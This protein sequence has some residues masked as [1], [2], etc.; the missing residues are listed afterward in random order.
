MFN[1]DTEINQFH[2]TRS[3]H[4]VMPKHHK[5]YHIIIGE[6]ARQINKHVD[7]LFQE[8]DRQK[9]I[10]EIIESKALLGDEKFIEDAV[11]FSI[12]N[13]DENTAFEYILESSQIAYFGIC[14]NLNIV[15]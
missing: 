4:R 12:L 13:L 15:T 11:M 3:Y 14:V 2:V 1:I 8:K 5:L 10:E 7:I 9:A 6:K